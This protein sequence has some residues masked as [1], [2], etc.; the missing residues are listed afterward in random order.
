MK[1][2]QSSGKKPSSY[3]F[4]KNH[5]KTWVISQG[6]YLTSIAAKVFN[7]VILNRIYGEISSRL[8]PFQVG[9]RWGKSCTEQIHFIRRILE[10]YQKKNIPTVMAFTDFKKAFDLIS[11]DTMWRIRRYYGIPE[12]I[13]NIIKC[14]YEGSTSAVR[15]DGSL[16]KGFLIT[17]GVLQ[18]ETLASFLLII[19]L[20]YVLRN[21]EATTDLQTHIQMNCCLTLIFQM[22]SFY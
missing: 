5:K 2:G 19:V 12:K 9:F 20:D 21:T 7:R 10:Q 1:K 13:V 22:A 11:R 16:S 18:G 15:V 14:L 3:Q 6:I 8:R 17:T 4:L